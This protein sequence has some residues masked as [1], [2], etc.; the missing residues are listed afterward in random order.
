[1]I[2]SNYSSWV[3]PSWG[4]YRDWRRKPNLILWT[5]SCL[6]RCMKTWRR[7]KQRHQRHRSRRYRRQRSLSHKEVYQG[8]FL[9]CYRE[10]REDWF[11]P[12]DRH[13]V[14]LGTNL[15]RKVFWS[16]R[17]HW[18]RTSVEQRQRRF[19]SIFSDT[20][21]DQRKLGGTCTGTE[22]GR[23]ELWWGRATGVFLIVA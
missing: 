23:T 1:M 12:I 14:S 6:K 15:E 8:E 16:L 3:S 13:G 17:N 2:I 19:W 9:G 22:H 5:S 7:R 21:V 10:L 4:W 20:W 18:K 11:Q